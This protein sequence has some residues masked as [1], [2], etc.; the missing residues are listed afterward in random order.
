M[1]PNLGE[2]FEGHYIYHEITNVFM[3]SDFLEHDYVDLLTLRDVNISKESPTTYIHIESPGNFE[4]YGTL[5][6]E[7][8][9]KGNNLVIR[10]PGILKV[11]FYDVEGE[12]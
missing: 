12:D 5:T 1:L 2:T 10:L 7:S 4:I 9:W 8:Q 3:E 6:Y 11:K